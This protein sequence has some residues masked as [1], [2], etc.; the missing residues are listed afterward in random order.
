MIQTGKK[1]WRCYVK[2]CPTFIKILEPPIIILSSNEDHK[3]EPRSE[4]MMQCQQLSA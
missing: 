4:Q 2:K 3:H 1:K